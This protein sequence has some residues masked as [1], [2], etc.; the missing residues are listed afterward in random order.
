VWLEEPEFVNLVRAN[1]NGLLGNEI[2]NPM[3]ALAKKLKILK[4]LVVKWER[5]KKLETKEE[6]VKIEME[7]DTLYTNYPGGFDEGG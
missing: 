5:K 2:L 3:D 1:W 4:S 7:L 6:P